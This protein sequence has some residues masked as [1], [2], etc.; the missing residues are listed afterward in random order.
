MLLR[1]NWLRHSNGYAIKYKILIF[2]FLFLMLASLSKKQK[3]TTRVKR[4]NLEQTVILMV[5]CCEN[6][7]KGSNLES[8]ASLDKLFKSCFMKSQLRE[9]CFLDRLCPIL[10]HPHT[11]IVAALLQYPLFTFSTHHIYSTY[12]LSSYFCIH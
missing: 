6:C 9:A 11:K 3:A 2:F 8:Y 5:K 7:F 4:E 10:L 12:I 1:A